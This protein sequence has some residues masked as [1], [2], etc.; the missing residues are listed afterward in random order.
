MSYLNERKFLVFKTV[1]AE[2]Q[3]GKNFNEEKYY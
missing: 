1:I 2:E 3:Q